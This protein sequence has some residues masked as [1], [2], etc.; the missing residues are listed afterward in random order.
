M[1][2]PFLAFSMCPGAGRHS[3]DFQPPGGSWMVCC[4][5]LVCA[6][7]VYL[8]MCDMLWRDAFHINLHV[9][10]NFLGIK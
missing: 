10:E 4:Y 2:G 9:L 1:R 7:R 6:G 5:P 3:D 8:R